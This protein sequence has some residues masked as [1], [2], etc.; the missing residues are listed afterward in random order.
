MPAEVNCVYVSK[1]NSL[2]RNIYKLYNLSHLLKLYLYI[3][4]ISTSCLPLTKYKS[5]CFLQ[6]IWHLSLVS[7]KLYIAWLKANLWS[8]PFRILNDVYTNQFP[9]VLFICAL[10]H[11]FIIVE[12]YVLATSDL[13]KS[14][15]DYTGL[16]HF[17]Q[18]LFG[19]N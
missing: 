1:I 16:V 7:V 19:S 4:F 17:L 12:G 13:S 14:S 15:L 3:N 6:V 8:R 2:M 11:H 5:I 18:E 9:V 10:L